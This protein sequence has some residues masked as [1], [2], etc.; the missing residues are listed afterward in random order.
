LIILYTS[1]ELTKKTI[2]LWEGG[3]SPLGL[4][5][6]QEKTGVTSVGNCPECVTEK[7][8]SQLYVLDFWLSSPSGEKVAGG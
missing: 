8:I 5:R 6:V 2:W 7:G 4:G 3:Q 1:V